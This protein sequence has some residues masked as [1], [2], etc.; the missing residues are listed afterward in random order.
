MCLQRLLHSGPSQ[1]INT[2]VLRVGTASLLSTARPDY[3]IIMLQMKAFVVLQTFYFLTLE[4][5]V[6]LLILTK[7][8]WGGA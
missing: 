8:S 6:K 7:G 5:D 3:H 1:F 2:S 4:C